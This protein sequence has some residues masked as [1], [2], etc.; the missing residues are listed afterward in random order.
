MRKLS[1]AFVVV[2]VGLVNGWGEPLGEAVS[3]SSVINWQPKQEEEV[4]IEPLDEGEDESEGEVQALVPIEPLKPIY[5]ECSFD[6]RFSEQWG[7]VEASRIEDAAEALKGTSQVSLQDAENQL[8][9][10]QAVEPT[11]PFGGLVDDWRDDD[12]LLSRITSLIANVTTSSVVEACAD[13]ALSLP[14]SG[15]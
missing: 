6:Y 7:G 10:L 2:A 5:L 11:L 12:Y 1:V 13:Y 3:A 14:L 15:A 8:L 9:M 4:I